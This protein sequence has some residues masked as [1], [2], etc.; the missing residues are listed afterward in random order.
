VGRDNVDAFLQRF[1]QFGEAGFVLAGCRDVTGK[2][3]DA[4]DLMVADHGVRN[5]IEVIDGI[6]T[7]EA[8]L[9]HAAPMAAFEEPRQRSVDEYLTIARGFFEEVRDVAA[10]NLLERET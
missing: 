9:N 2:D 1:E 3:R 8:N 4:V 7:L 5:A 6:R 10:N